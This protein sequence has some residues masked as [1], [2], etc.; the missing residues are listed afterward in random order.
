M[1]EGHDGGKDVLRDGNDTVKK[2]PGVR[3]AVSRGRN[4]ISHPGDTDWIPEADATMIGC[5]SG[6][7]L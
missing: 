2:I 4:Y 7:D 5:L 1:P 3:Y 6:S